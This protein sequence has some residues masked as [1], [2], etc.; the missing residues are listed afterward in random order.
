[1]LLA[2]ISLRLG[3]QRLWSARRRLG[4]ADT[5]LKMDFLDHG[6][7]FPLQGC[8]VPVIVPRIPCFFAAEILRLCPYFGAKSKRRRSGAQWFSRISLY[9]SLLAGNLRR[10]RVRRR[11]RPQPADKAQWSI[12]E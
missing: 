12:G 11:L 10:R 7:V 6:V 4:I 1:M 3:A 5:A 2:R 8:G 9:F